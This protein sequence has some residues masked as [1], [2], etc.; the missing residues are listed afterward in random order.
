MGYYIACAP[1][2]RE[3]GEDGDVRQAAQQALELRITRVVGE[4]LHEDLDISN[5]TQAKVA[6]R[7]TFEVDADFADI[8]ETHGKRQ[9]RGRLRRSWRRGWT[10]VNAPGP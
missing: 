4:G 3:G 8:E 5:H 10:P 1:A 2:L 9:Q 7:L 6:F